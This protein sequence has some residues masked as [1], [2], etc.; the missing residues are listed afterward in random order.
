MRRKGGDRTV[1]TLLYQ[2]NVVS[3]PD[4]IPLSFK[5]L[6]CEYG[7]KRGKYHSHY[8]YLMLFFKLRKKSK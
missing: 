3:K 8:L 1:T 4:W 6:N 5:V 7:K 2:Q